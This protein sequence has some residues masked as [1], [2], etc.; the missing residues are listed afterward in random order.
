MMHSIF[1]GFYEKLFFISCKHTASSECISCVSIAISQVSS[2]LFC[3]RMENNH[4]YDWSFF[5]FCSLLLF[6]FQ[7]N[8]EMNDSKRVND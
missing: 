1:H 2:E 5:L 8:G 3:E 4:H 6:K 7:V